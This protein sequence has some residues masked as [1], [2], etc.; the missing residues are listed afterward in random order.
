VLQRSSSAAYGFVPPWNGY[1]SP[2]FTRASL[3]AR[4]ICPQ[5]LRAY[6]LLSNPRIGSSGA[7]AGSP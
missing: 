5:R 6:S 2:G 3:R 1:G 7:K 4:L